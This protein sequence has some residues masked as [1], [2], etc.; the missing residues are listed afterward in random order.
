MFGSKGSISSTFYK[1][2][3]MPANPKSA[4]NTAKLLVL[5]ALLVSMHVRAALKKS[6]MKLTEG[7]SGS[8]LLYDRCHFQ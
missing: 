4:K 3:I 6:L 7:L 5:F 2:A 1:V 8:D